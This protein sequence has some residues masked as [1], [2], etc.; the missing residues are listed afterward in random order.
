MLCPFFRKL[1][2]SVS[3]LL[4]YEIAV[5]K[6]WSHIEPGVGNCLF[7]KPGTGLSIIGLLPTTGENFAYPQSELVN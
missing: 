1:N 3:F 6:W 4:L 7:W 2:L 5:S